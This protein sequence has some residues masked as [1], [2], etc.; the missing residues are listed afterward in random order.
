VEILL[1]SQ[2]SVVSV[3]FGSIATHT[4]VPKALTLTIN[5]SYWRSTSNRKE[6]YTK[7]NFA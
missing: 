2:E 4:R 7:T 5:N 1:L 6:T 3:H